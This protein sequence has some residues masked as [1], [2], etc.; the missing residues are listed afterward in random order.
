[1][2]SGQASELD[3]TMPQPEGLQQEIWI[4]TAM[5]MVHI[6]DENLG[7]EVAAKRW[8]CPLTRDNLWFTLASFGVTPKSQPVKWRAILDLH[9]LDIQTCTAQK[10]L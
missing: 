7:Q 10:I 4:K 9:Q 8:L 2:D 1:M 3:L 6:V 5:E